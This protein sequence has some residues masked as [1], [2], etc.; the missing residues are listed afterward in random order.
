[1]GLDFRQSNAHWSYSGFN[2]FRERLAKA[3]GYNLRKMWELEDSGKKSF[4][5]LPMHDFYFHSDCDGVLTVR[6]LKVILPRFRE[7]LEILDSEG[8]EDDYDVW[9]GKI[10]ADD[11][12][13]CIINREKL[14]FC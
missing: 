13:Q 12:E 14:E 2:R 8:I 6:Q 5:D 4:K 1:M 7:L 11:M 3:E 10:L 9:S